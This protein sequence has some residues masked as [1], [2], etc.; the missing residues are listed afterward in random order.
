MLDAF[1]QVVWEGTKIKLRK[2]KDGRLKKG[3]R[4]RGKGSGGGGRHGSGGRNKYKKQD[5]FRGEFK[6]KKKGKGGGKFKPSDK[7]KGY[8]GKKRKRS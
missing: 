8:T 6:P 7:N 2:L 1:E 4:G 5:D 3:G